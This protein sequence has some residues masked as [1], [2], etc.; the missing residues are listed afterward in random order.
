MGGLNVRRT[1]LIDRHLTAHTV[2]FGQL[3]ARFG[4]PRL[5]ISSMR[6]A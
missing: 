1:E 2:R 4:E 3:L 6:A 5:F